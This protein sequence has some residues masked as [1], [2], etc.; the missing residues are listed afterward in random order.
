ME[1]LLGELVTIESPSDDPD[2]L[3]AMGGRLERLFGEFGGVERHS[4]GQPGVDHLVVTVPG[5]GPESLAHTV[6]LG[7]FDTVWPRGTL[8]RMPFDVSREGVATG[9]GCFDMKGGLVLLYYAL[10]ELSALGLGSRRTLRL[11]LNSD[12]EIGSRSSRALIKDAAAGAA[13]AFVLEAPLPGGVLKTARKGTAMYRLKV[14]GKAA[15]AGIEPERGVSAI[16]ELAHQ[17]PAVHALNDLVS[18]TSVTV[19]LVRGG[20]RSNVVPAAAEAVIDVRVKTAAEA[21]RVRHALRELSPVLPGARVSVLADLSRPPMERTPASGRLFQRAKAISAGLGVP[22]LGEGSTGG[23]SDG[24]LVAALGVPTLDGLGP[25]G[26]GAHADDEHVKV[27][28]LPRRAAL[29]AGLLAE[30]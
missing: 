17:I 2:G 16:L 24:N 10:S 15:H 4:A 8:E 20:S 14:E 28:C 6:A 9:P 12:E 18:G 3:V 30:V 25:E 21:E 22:D 19:G 1:Q 11:V 26:G 7:H 23:G 29:I 5:A 13:A 27:D